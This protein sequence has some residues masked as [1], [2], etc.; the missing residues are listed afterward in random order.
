MS[1]DLKSNSSSYPSQNTEPVATSAEVVAQPPHGETDE[2]KETATKDKNKRK[3]QLFTPKKLAPLSKK[4][5]F[6][7]ICTVFSSAVLA[8]I[9]FYVF[10]YPSKFAP[11]GVDG[12]ATMLQEST[13][14]NAGYYSLLFNIPVLVVAYFVLNKRYVF[15]TV[16][17]TLLN[18]LFLIVLESC[19][20]P[21]Y[22]TDTDRLLPAI[23]S[24]FIL[25]VRSG[26]LLKM[27]ASTG[28]VD[29]LACMVQKKRPYLNVE[30][31]IAIISY[32]IIAAS[33][34]VYKDIDSIL[35][36][37]AQMFVLER[38]AATFMRDNRNAVEFKIVTK[39]PEEIRE[40]IL[41]SLRH[42]ATLVESKGMFTEREST[43]IFSVVNLRQI[44]DFLNILKKYPDTFVYYSEVTGVWGN[45]RRNKND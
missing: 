34:I 37:V 2:R 3:K 21:Q 43:V 12:I 27:G 24:G 39:H 30:R 14:V 35:L 6:S 38:T 45:F 42:G 17:F 44:P 22:H 7:D 11:G 9:G 19:S 28:G 33:Y 32:V 31:I 4:R 8:A 40:E 15:Y 1:P 13:G 41:Y 29:V 25:G 10:V 18:S 23:F 36:S 5:V 26:L 20:F 16:L